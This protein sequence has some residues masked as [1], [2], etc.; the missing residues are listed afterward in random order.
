MSAATLT[1]QINGEAVAP[2][3]AVWFQV[4]PCGCTGAVT[5]AH[6]GDPCYQHE[7]VLTEE[8]AWREFYE[9]VTGAAEHMRRD[10]ALGYRVE[11]GLRSAVKDRLSGDCPHSPKWG[12]VTPPPSGHVWA[13]DRGSKREH[14]VPGQKGEGRYLAGTWDGAWKSEPVVA[15]CGRSSKWW[16]T[17][18]AEDGV[19]SPHCTRCEKAAFAGGDPR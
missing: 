5:V 19:G 17:H 4:A 6:I 11:L 10:K 1:F 7:P 18:W 15:L 8:A 12:H 13:A 16:T 14:L 9:G 2:T 3:D